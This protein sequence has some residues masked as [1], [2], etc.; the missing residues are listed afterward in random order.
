MI[1]TSLR[2]AHTV[3]IM[4]LGQQHRQPWDLLEVQQEQQSHILAMQEM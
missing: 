3:K 1:W 2:A 4:G